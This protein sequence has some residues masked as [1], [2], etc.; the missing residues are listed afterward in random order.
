MRGVRALVLIGMALFGGACAEATVSGPTTAGNNASLTIETF[1]GT[2]PVGGSRFFSF[3]VP[4]SGLIT[5]TLVSLTQA[6]EATSAQVLLSLGAPRGTDCPAL[7]ARVAGVD[8]VPQLSLQPQ[9]GVYC[10]RIADSG[11]LTDAVDFSINIVHP[12]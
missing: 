8:V 9:P 4:R 6:G 5:L 2:L 11:Q 7:D 12:R 10:A 3:T 1:G